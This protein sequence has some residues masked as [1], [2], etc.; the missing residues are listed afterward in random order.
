MT[1]FRLSICCDTAAFD[2][3]DDDADA[4]A[5]GEALR[6]ELGRILRE[7]GSDTLQLRA[8]LYEGKVFDRNGNTVGE[9][10]IEG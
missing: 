2:T 7:L 4:M 8:L 6:Q 3:N 10:R 5:R 1:T 9:W